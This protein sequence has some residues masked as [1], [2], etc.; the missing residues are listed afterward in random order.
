VR[1][2]I[3]VADVSAD[4]SIVAL[5]GGHGLSASLRAL[6][7]VTNRLTAIVGVADDGGSSGRLRS[8][9]G[10][11][12]PGDLRM[13][14]AALCGDDSWGRTWEKV[15][16]HRFPGDGDLGG[17]A[18]GNLLITALWQSTH[19]AVEGLDWVGA[20][21]EAQGRVLPLSET[22]LDIVARIY[23]HNPKFPDE[24][25]Q[26]RGQVEVATTHGRVL[27]VWV[28]PTDAPACSEAIT[29][30]GSADAVVLGPG[31]WF[32]SVMPHLLIPAQRQALID[33]SAQRILV[34]NLLPQV[35]E[36]TGFQPEEYVR[37]LRESTPDL[38]VDV[39]LA[40]PGHVPDV[41]ALT[42]ECELIGAEL[43]LHPL[44]SSKDPAM[45][46]PRRLSV[47]FDTVLR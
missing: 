8:E 44:A 31:S 29:A 1:R 13:A 16:Q 17:H 3:P 5:G 33:T 42:S 12:P 20:L 35:G 14:L 45:H 43:A 4:P 9:F 36:T 32:T 41:A 22:P 28:E 27:D 38:R 26:V 34:V 30:I 25:V 6:R 24:V 37:V 7:Q 39:V 47:A 23:G 10:V 18:M 46:D 19:D 21:L 40:D 15:V 2:H 11:L